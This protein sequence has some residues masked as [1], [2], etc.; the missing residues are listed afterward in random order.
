MIT[1]VVSAIK[2]AFAQ[3]F[4]VWIRANHLNL[5][6]EFLKS[7]LPN[8]LN[9][10]IRVVVVTVLISARYVDCRAL[11]TF[12]EGRSANDDELWSEGQ[13]E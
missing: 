4:Q 9:R 7:I 3:K 11:E 6:F 5:S 8:G 10:S 1:I 12:L 2:C 13:L